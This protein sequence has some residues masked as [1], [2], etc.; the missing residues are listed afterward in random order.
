M[1]K[2]EQFYINISEE[3]NFSKKTIVKEIKNILKLKENWPIIYILQNR[4]K[5]EI[6]IGESARICNRI[7]CHLNNEEKNSTFDKAIF[8]SSEHFNKSVTLDIESK[9]IQYLSS[10]GH[11][12]LHNKNY[13]LSNHDYYQKKEYELLFHDLW[14][15]LLDKKFVNK[16]LTKVRDTD[17]FIYSPYK[18]LN[19]E[20]YDSAIEILKHLASPLSHNTI[21]VKGSA[22]TGKT[23]LATYLIKL[24]RTDLSSIVKDDESLLL[25]ETELIQKFQK[26]SLG[27][28]K[29]ALVIAMT[30]L[31]GTLKKVF[32]N[33]KGLEGSLVIGP[34]D[35][36]K[37]VEQYDLLIVDE[38]HRL[39]Q[40]E[41]IGW[42]GQFRK[43]SSSL[44]LDPKVANEL[45]WI[46][47][48]SKNQIFFYDPL[49][50]VMP[51]DINESRFSELLVKE[52]TIHLKLKSQ[53]RINGGE[54]Y[55]AFVDDLLNLRLE[56]Q[57]KYASENY[58]L[59]L[60]D[61]FEDFRQ[62]HYK[63]EQEHG[64]SR[65][66]AGYSWEWLS[67]NDKEKFDIEIEGQMLRWNSTNKDWINSPNAKN[68]IGC[69]HTIQ[70]YEVNYIGV[71]FGREISYNKEKNI[72][73]I[74]P[75]LYFDRNGKKGISNDELKKKIINIYRVLMTRG[76]KGTFVYVWDNNLREYFRQHIQEIN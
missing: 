34:S 21:F 6:Y 73:E 22:G 20:Q 10:E 46:M 41:S 50:T 54:D 11:Y 14:A 19:N 60:F 28:P 62:M 35:I 40:D 63:K 74:N 3:C 72:I 71:I 31:R 1:K 55:L 17:L 29:I 69:I 32:R 4:K 43:N 53:M 59:S 30:S 33:V 38:A 70:G 7:N 18:S 68:E 66:V 47:K 42:S 61:S 39:R 23:V 36:V 45:D 67:K 16:S 26:K 13:G 57:K 2:N 52:E 5:K 15:K 48:K 37:S 27:T 49:Q 12:K 56:I 58:E 24:L 9:L 64:L 8:I 75:K 76:T 25:P 65:L 51:S 44:N